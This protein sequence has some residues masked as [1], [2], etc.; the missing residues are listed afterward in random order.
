MAKVAFVY[1]IECTYKSSKGYSIRDKWVVSSTG[2]VQAIDLLPLI[3][4]A[5]TLYSKKHANILR[6]RFGSNK[7]ALNSAINS[8]NFEELYSIEYHKWDFIVK[9]IIKFG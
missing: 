5:K 1:T 7:Q 8:R 2:M 3:I 4:K 6:T 9:D